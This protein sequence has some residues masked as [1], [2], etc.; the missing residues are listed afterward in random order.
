MLLIFLIFCHRK[1]TELM[2]I[3]RNR[4]LKKPVN[5]TVLQRAVLKNTDWFC[6]LA[7]RKIGKIFLQIPLEFSKTIF[8]PKC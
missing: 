5:S 8:E 7:A 6:V 2:G 3:S 4:S 1:V